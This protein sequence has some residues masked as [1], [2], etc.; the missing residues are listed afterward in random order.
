MC[1]LKLVTAWATCM[2]LPDLLYYCKCKF[3]RSLID[4][5]VREAFTRTGLAPLMWYLALLGDIATCIPSSRTAGFFGERGR[6]QLKGVGVY[7]A[8]RGGQ[9]PERQ[10]EGASLRAKA[11]AL[12]RRLEGLGV[13]L[14]KRGKR[15]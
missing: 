1:F 6:R 12:G 7:L 15:C 4:V 2:S 3:F 11:A 14:S 5:V 9:Q 13:V 10:L 8:E